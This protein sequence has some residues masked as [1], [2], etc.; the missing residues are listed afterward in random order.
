M[1][2]FDRIGTS[3]LCQSSHHQSEE[4]LT[5]LPFGLLD[6]NKTCRWRG[7]KH[8]EKRWRDPRTPGEWACIVNEVDE[9][10]PVAPYSV[11][12]NR[13]GLLPAL[14]WPWMA[15]NRNTLNILSKSFIV[16]HFIKNITK[17]HTIGG[18]NSLTNGGL[19]PSTRKLEAPSGGT[20]DDPTR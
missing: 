15:I 5:V 4:S 1:T 16:G 9:G 11:D 2:E 10:P 13:P 12:D 19:P 6:R 7:V 20:P 18:G 17:E 14:P 3:S 8:C